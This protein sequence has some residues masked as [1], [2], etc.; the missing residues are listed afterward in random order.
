MATMLPALF[1]SHFAIL[2]VNIIFI[3]KY[4]APNL[5]DYFRS[6]IRVFTKK[7]RK[8]LKKGMVGP[9]RSSRE[10]GRVRIWSAD[11]YGGLTVFI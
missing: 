6:R 10:N 1:R 7:S 11:K 4:T 2:L 5:P 3:Y 9:K 8:M